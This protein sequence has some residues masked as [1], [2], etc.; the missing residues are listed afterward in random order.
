MKNSSEMFLLGLVNIIAGITVAI[1]FHQFG[2][3][4]VISGVL[5][6]IQAKWARNLIKILYLIVSVALVVLTGKV[7]FTAGWIKDFW[8]MLGVLV[9]FLTVQSIL[10]SRLNLKR[11]QAYFHGLADERMDLANKKGEGWICPEC[12]NVNKYSR[13]C[14][15]CDTPNLD[16]QEDEGKEEQS[17]KVVVESNEEAPLEEKNKVDE[18]LEKKENGTKETSDLK[19][20]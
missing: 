6:F 4:G 19:E 9:S 3:I 13:Q 18:F 16:P 11:A 5:Y 10:I 15:N 2:L 12:N 1:S 14:W 8:I 7:L 20:E 17:E